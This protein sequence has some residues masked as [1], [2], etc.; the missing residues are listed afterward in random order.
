MEEASKNRPINDAVTT[1]FVNLC[2]YTYIGLIYRL[3]F[4][5]MYIGHRDTDVYKI[6]SK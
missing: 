1:A 3:V 4:I 2:I 6:E 5:H